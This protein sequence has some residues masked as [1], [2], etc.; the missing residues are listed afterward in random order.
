MSRASRPTAL[1]DSGL[2]LLSRPPAR[3]A[4]RLLSGPSDLKL[5]TQRREVGGGRHLDIVRPA[6]CGEDH[7]EVGP[8]L[9]GGWG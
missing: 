9:R 2:S 7:R 4:K 5:C 1:C 6:H 3:S 8:H